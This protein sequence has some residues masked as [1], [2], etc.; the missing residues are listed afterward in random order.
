MHGCGFFGQENVCSFADNSTWSPAAMVFFKKSCFQPIVF[1]TASVRYRRM[2]LAHTVRYPVHGHPLHGLGKAQ[3]NDGCSIRFAI[4]QL[5][6]C[7]LTEFFLCQG[8]NGMI[9]SNRPKKFRV[10]KTAA[11]PFHWLPV[12]SG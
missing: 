11:E 8:W 6:F 2:G 10:K 7:N 3:L 4:L 5:F 1:R 12:P 9:A